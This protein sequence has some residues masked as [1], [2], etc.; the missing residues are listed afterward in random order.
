[1]CARGTIG[2]KKVVV[3]RSLT[4]RVQYSVSFRQ[5]MSIAYSVKLQ[6]AQY[7]TNARQRSAQKLHAKEDIQMT[8]DR[9]EL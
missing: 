4:G 2:L 6:Y 7:R 1:M 8:M 9:V 5:A 3:I